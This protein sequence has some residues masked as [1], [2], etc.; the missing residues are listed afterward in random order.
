[1]IFQMSVADNSRFIGFISESG[2]APLEMTA[3]IS[4]SLDP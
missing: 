4:P 1:M 3:K 2:P